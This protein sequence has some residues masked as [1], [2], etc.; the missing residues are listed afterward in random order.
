MD[1][2][3]INSAQVVSNGIKIHGLANARDSVSGMVTIVL[4]ILAPM[5]DYGMIL[6]SLANAQEIKF[7]L[8][9]HVF[10]HKLFAP[11]DR[12]GTLLSML[13]LA[14]TKHSKDLTAVYPF[15]SA[16]EDKSTTH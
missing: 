4:L 7:G 15:L 1:V 12:S 11:M 14:L 13:A 2:C 3:S 6:S 9:N 10:L 5:V 8:I 16:M